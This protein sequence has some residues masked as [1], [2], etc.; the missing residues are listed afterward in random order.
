MKFV[1]GLG[2]P[3]VRY[4]FTR[5]NI[6]FLVLDQLAEKYDIGLSTKKLG[7]YVGKG[8]IGDHAVLLAQ[9]QDFMN[10]SGISVRKLF[11]FFKITNIEDV[12]VVHDDLD[13]PFNSLRLKA[14]GGHGG[15]KGLIS[16]ISNLGGE[17]FVRVRVGIGK[18]AGKSMVEGYV[19]SSFSESEVQMLPDIVGCAVD[20]VGEII[21][22]DI[23]TAM[24][25]Y[26]V[27]K[28]NNFN[29]EV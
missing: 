2:N 24:N 29:E 19:L 28:I 7:S 25:M 8:K 10:L 15:H 3:G 11:D 6:G 9:P 16:I 22:S 20:A 23:Q 21:S 13:L 26:N 17:A 27:K 1:V 5:H 4:R 18:P 12:I 14:G